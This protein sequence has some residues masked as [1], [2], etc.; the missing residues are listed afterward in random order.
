L[1]VTPAQAGV[2]I[3]DFPG[4]ANASRSKSR[5]WQDGV[6]PTSLVAGPPQ[7]KA[8]GRR[9]AEGWFRA[10][11]CYFVAHKAAR[12]A[13]RNPQSTPLSEQLSL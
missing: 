4:F 10:A 3:V 13:S 1:L 8:V 7:D 2:Q 9:T 11:E 12:G 6:L 5:R